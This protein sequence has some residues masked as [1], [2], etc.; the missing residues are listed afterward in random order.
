MSPVTQRLRRF[1][2]TEEDGSFIV[3]AVLVLPL[4]LWAYLGLFT[5]WDAYRA[6]TLSQKAGYTV[7]DMISREQTPV[8]AAYFAG[9]KQTLDYMLF[10]EF[11]SRMRVSSVVYELDT[12]LM[13]IEWSHSTAPSAVAPLT[14]ETLQGL[15]SHIPEMSDG[16]TV[17][18]LETWVDFEPALNI[19]L[20]NT[21]FQEFI[22]TRPRFA[23][24][25]VMQ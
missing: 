24:R 23:P 12:D 20:A 17:I 14:N 18:L 1:L 5:Y 6:M 9:M 15:A 11:P 2:K 8:N 22:V 10:R 16:D 25:I 4:L 3:E 7:S 21:T 19:G 13:S